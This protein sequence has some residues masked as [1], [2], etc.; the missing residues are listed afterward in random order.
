MLIQLIW[1][2][3]GRGVRTFIIPAETLPPGVKD[4]ILEANNLYMGSED[5]EEEAKAFA[6]FDEIDAGK[7]D[8]FEVTHLNTESGV[9][10]NS[11]TDYVDGILIDGKSDLTLKHLVI[12]GEKHV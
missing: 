12:S 3:N 10:E 11:E 2:T 6:L 5:K 1:L 4:V 7:F 8:K 9:Y